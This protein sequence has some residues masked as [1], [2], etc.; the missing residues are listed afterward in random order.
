MQYQAAD[1]QMQV[2]I[3]AYLCPHF[4]FPEN[5]TF[6]SNRARQSVLKVE[7]LRSGHIIVYWFKCMHLSVL[8]QQDSL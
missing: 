3:N 4:Y 2:Y 8:L 1:R 5:F 7:K 6:Y